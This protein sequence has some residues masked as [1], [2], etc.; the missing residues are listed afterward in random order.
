M[1]GDVLEPTVL[2]R[3]VPVFYAFGNVNDVTGLKFDCRFAPFLIPALSADTNQ[4]LV[5][6]VVD[7]SV[8]PA[9]GL[10][11]DIAVA[12]DSGLFLRKILWP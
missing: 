4:N 6:S 10:E 7:V 9:S 12:L 2:L 3:S 11:G 1:S 8:V 5:R